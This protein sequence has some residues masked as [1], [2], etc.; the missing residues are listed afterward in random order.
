MPKHIRKSNSQKASTKETQKTKKTE[1][2]TKAKKVNFEL[3]LKWKKGTKPFIYQKL[4]FT[5]LPNF[6]KAV[7]EANSIKDLLIKVGGLESKKVR[8]VGIAYE[9]M[10]EAFQFEHRHYITKKA[11]EIR[12]IISDAKTINSKTK[13]LKTNKPIEISKK[14]KSYSTTI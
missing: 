3:I 11:K 2:K 4:L 12:K 13:N 7:E 5:C 10:I 8:I 9:G 14:V 6:N 1:Q